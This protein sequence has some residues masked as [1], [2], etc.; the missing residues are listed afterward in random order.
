MS[1]VC[2]VW[3]RHACTGNQLNVMPSVSTD[4]PVLS[5]SAKKKK[6]RKENKHNASGVKSSDGDSSLFSTSTHPVFVSPPDPKAMLKKQI[7]EAKAAKV[8]V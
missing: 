1:G 4:T 5:K 8:S 3:A 2:V 6:K 7:E